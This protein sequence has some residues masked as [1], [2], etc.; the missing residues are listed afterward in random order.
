MQDFDFSKRAAK[1]DSGIEGKVSRKFYDAVLAQVDIKPGSNVLDVGCGTG[2]LLRKMRQQADF[3]GYGIDVE[4]EMISVAN[5]ACPDM[6]IQLSSCDATPFEDNM[7]D[8]VAACMAYHH[9]GNKEGFVQEVSRIIKTGGVLHIADPCFP[10]VIR[11]AINIL[12]RLF[13]K[14]GAFFS[15]EELVA[16]FALFGFEKQAVYRKGFVQVVALKRSAA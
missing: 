11:K 5:Q 10:L 4:A 14:T 15:P 9:F 2:Y 1:Y 7:F 3:A 8:V 16:Q 6:D 12:A 13:K